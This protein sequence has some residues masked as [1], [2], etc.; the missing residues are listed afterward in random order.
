VATR[1]RVVLA[2]AL[3]IVSVRIVHAETVARHAFLVGIADYTASQLIGPRQPVPLDRDWR[4]LGGPVNDVE[5]MTDLLSVLYEFQKTDIVMLRDQNAT[6]A[7]ILGGFESLIA[8]TRKGDVVFV[9]LAGHG[10]HVTNSLSSEPDKLDEAF[11]PAD[12]RLGVRDIRDKE[13]R[14]IFN[15]LLDRGARLTVVLDACFSASGAR[16]F[17]DGGGV[18]GVRPDPRDVAD[19]ADAGPRPEDRGALV[20]AAA[21]DFDIAYEVRDEKK[22]RGAFTWALARSLREAEPGEPAIDTFLRAQAR[23]RGEMPLQEP[24]IAGN[25]EARLTPFLSTGEP[26][27]EKRPVI[28]VE[29]E[30]RTGTFMVQGG[31]VNGITVGS[32]LQLKN[33]S[34]LRLEVTSLDGI[35]R[36]EARVTTPSRGIQSSLD[37]GALLELVVWAA[38]P[39]RRLRVSVSRAPDSAIAF[40]RTIVIA[41][42]RR[43]IRLVDDPVETP[44]T[45]V[46]R[47]RDGAW[48]LLA[49]GRNP[50]RFGST[51]AAEIA[52][53]IPADAAL[54]VHVPAPGA[55]I[56]A[57]GLQSAE[58]G[59]IDVSDAPESAD[60]ILV[61]RT[62]KEH[63]E[64]AWVR[65]LASMETRHRSSLP[66]RT[67]WRAD[68]DRTTPLALHDAV[69]KL[70]RIH[71]WLHLES[72]PG[73]VLQ[74]RLAIHRADD[75]QVVR[76]GR[77]LGE[78]RY[79]LVLSR[80]SQSEPATQRYFYVFSI[81]SDG[82]SV[83][84]F[85]RSGSV[86]NRFPIEQPSE[87][88]APP[89]EI[90]LGGP[91]SFVAR[92]PYGADT[93][94]LLA[95]DEALP[96]P[97]CLES[98]G[99]RG[100]QRRSA[101]E[102]LMTLA[103]TGLRS[104]GF[105]RVSPNWS[106][107]KIVFES[108]PPRAGH[109]AG[110]VS[111]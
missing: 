49:R 89:R 24:V 68:V 19:G 101:L 40:A 100:P 90:P 9:F 42:A 30:I 20:L 61:G 12:S 82:R 51:S 18:R 77:L 33:R 59:G 56:D 95:T 96:N 71:G 29:R 85:P 53:A 48:Q 44:A 75:D 69:M 108:I 63:V 58:T 1:S 37:A 27:R 99:V 28:A 50:V 76:D 73:S 72:P 81:D 39:G 98:R 88:A 86:E 93:F 7:A 2:I 23:L 78:S 43:G 34:D 66:P 55:L 21:Q 79:R 46:I 109:E 25:T 70:R 83:L 52:A 103:T 97:W 38:P 35:A 5:L 47:W 94:F 64:Y 3:T 102:E 67:A 80:V 107:D 60:Y 45:H 41:A 84:L 8:K 15:R 105:F 36:C 4:N 31:W 74:Y 65:P 14:R 110:K 91:V 104:P 87:G 106:I 16:G 22:I 54:F 11:V 57:I 62:L 26:R 6:R 111:S 13:L 17:D 10:S 92:E 32:V